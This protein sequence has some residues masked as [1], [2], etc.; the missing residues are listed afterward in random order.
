MR[1]RILAAAALTFTFA[2]S[3]A[4]PAGSGDAG[5]KTTL[6]TYVVEFLRRN[7][8]TNTYLGGAGF[9]PALKDIDGKLRDHSVGALLAEDQWLN[10]QRQQLE[11]IPAPSLS[12]DAA[13]D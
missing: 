5:L 4:P 11:K 1:T 6:H 8:T 12:A 7:P 10:D 2:C 13:I 3:S 9:D